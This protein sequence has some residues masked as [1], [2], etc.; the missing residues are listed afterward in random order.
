MLSSRRLIILSAIIGLAVL[1][2]VARAAQVQLVEGQ[3]YGA[4][5]AGQQILREDVLAPRG[6]IFDR[7]GSLLAVSNRAYMV[8]VDTSTLTDTQAVASA[9]A[10]VMREP[11]EKIRQQLQ[12]VLNDVKA[13][14]STRSTLVAYNLTPQATPTHSG[15]SAAPRS[16]S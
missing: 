13:V 12:A 4:A 14:T 2:A 9:L 8:R 7:N 5:A 3:D 16:V 15:R 11:T 10:P 6:A 1:V